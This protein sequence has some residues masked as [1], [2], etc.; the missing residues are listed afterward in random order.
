MT[1]QQMLKLMDQAMEDKVKYDL[2]IENQEF[3]VRKPLSFANFI[4]DQLMMQYGL[5]ALAIKSIVHMN[6]G[7]KNCEDSPYGSYLSRSVGLA[8]PPLRRDEIAVIQRCHF[9]F[10]E[11]QTD[12]IK[13]YTKKSTLFF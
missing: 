2:D 8:L 12:W 11:T 7:L 4:Y 6:N 1:E 5:K 10:K 3:S 9:F 13:R